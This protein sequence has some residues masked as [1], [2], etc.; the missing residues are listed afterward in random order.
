M[1][2]RSIGIEY[3]GFKKRNLYR[4]I[5]VKYFQL[6]CTASFRSHD[7]ICTINHLNIIELRWTDTQTIGDNYSLCYSIIISLFF[8]WP[9]RFRSYLY[10]SKSKQKPDILSIKSI[11]RGHQFLRIR[12]KIGTYALWSVWSLIIPFSLCNLKRFAIIIGETIG[13]MICKFNYKCCWSC[14]NK[15]ITWRWPVAGFALKN[16]D[17]FKSNARVM[18]FIWICAF[19]SFFVAWNI[20]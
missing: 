13:A 3:N 7:P 18:H 20:E 2:R 16:H 6:W 10:F 4:I 11:K 8:V 9:I 17:A 15:T 1:N 19:Y 14:E 5:V 12:L